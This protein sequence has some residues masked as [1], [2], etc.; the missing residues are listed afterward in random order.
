MY[1]FKVSFPS[2]IGY[3]NLAFRSL[4]CAGAGAAAVVACTCLGGDYVGGDGVDVVVLGSFESGRAPKC[5]AAD[6]E[7]AVAAERQSLWPKNRK[8]KDLKI[9]KSRRA[10]IKG[11]TASQSL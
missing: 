9:K 10:Q 2:N 1:R 6:A 4:S 11:A 7:S 5:P 8:K 3:T